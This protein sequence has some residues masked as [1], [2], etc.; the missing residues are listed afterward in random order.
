MFPTIVYSEQLFTHL[1]AL[2]ISLEFS[3]KREKR[4]YTPNSVYTAAYDSQYPSRQE[5]VVYK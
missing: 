1:L 3:S 2:I 4:V 5:R